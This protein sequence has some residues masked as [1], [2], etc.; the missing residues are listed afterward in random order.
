MNS[1]NKGRVI[2]IDAV[3]ESVRA[4]ERSGLARAITLVESTRADHRDLAQQLLLRVL[5]DAGGSHRVGITGVPG[6][7]KSTF[8]DA[9]GMRL[10]E[11]GHRVAVLAVDPSSTRTGGS[12]LGDKTRM[13]RLAVQENAYIRPSPTSGTLGG[14][15]RATRETIVLLEAAGFDVILVETVGVGQSEVTVANMVDCFTFLTLARTGDQLQGIKKGVLELADLVA[16][17]KADG[18]HATDAKNAARELAGALRLIYPHDAIWK[19]PVLTMSAIEGTGLDEYWN[20]VLRHQQVLRDAGEF[21]EKRRKQ[22]VD[23]TWTMV[24]DQLLRR[25]AQSPSVKAIRDDVESRVRDGSLTAALAAQE[26][27]DAFDS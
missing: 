12:I 22:Q 3:A 18:K 6:V 5:P 13:S 14:V 15:A 4:N 7:G 26:L 9:L 27:L 2:D 11:Q 1:P 25:L 20:T 21:A 16:V 10:I 23:W 8:I 19:P 17:N 24:N